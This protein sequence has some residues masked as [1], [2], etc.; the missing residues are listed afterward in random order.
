MGQ[1]R[2]V[3][4]NTHGGARKGAGRKKEHRDRVK[5]QIV[6]DR[7]LLNTID[8]Y[9]QNKNVNRSEFFQQLASNFL[10]ASCLNSSD[11]VQNQ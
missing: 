9:L 5:L 7:E 4:K 11:R 6:I 2:S 10:T 3:A 8:E 1:L